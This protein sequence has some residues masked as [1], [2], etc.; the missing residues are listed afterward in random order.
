MNKQE[1]LH[2]HSLFAEIKN[3]IVDELENQESNEDESVL[4][5][6][7]DSKLISKYNSLNVKH[8]DIHKGKE[9][10]KNAVLILATIVSQYIDYVELPAKKEKEVRQRLSDVQ[11]VQQDD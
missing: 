6:A 7:V 1:L 10:H 11:R 5:N 3:Y 4:C 2:M 9:A 8:T